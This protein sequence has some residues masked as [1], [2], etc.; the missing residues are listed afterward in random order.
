[1]FI[2]VVKPLGHVA[3]GWGAVALRRLLLRAAD[4]QCAHGSPH[5]WHLTASLCAFSSLVT[6]A[7]PS[8]HGR[9]AVGGDRVARSA[10]RHSVTR[11]RALCASTLTSATRPLTSRLGAYA[12]D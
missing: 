6:A 11:V 3:R 1:M 10:A 12:A 2:F 9:R 7:C 4:A 5:P 8:P